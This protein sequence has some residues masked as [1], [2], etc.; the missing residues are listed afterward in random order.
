LGERVVAGH[1]GDGKV[2]LGVLLE[3]AAP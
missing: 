3:V 1:L 2:K